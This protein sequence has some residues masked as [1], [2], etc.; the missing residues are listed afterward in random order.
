VTRRC[1]GDRGSAT[2]AVLVLMFAFTS[3]AVVWLARDVDRAVSNR[4]AAQ[5]IAFQAARTGA[6]Q[7]D[8]A[9]LRADG[10][11]A[12][13]ADAARLAATG[14]A[15]GLFDAYGLAGTVTAV[16]VGIDRVSVTVEVADAGRTVTGRGTARAQEG[17]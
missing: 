3:G 2:V 13:D 8:V 7:V 16:D 14:T 9:S 12:I 17:P 11:P 15:N 5:S 10:T 1:Q 6:Q 4:S